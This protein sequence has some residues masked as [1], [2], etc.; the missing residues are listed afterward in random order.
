MQ[1]QNISKFLSI[2]VSDEEKKPLVGYALQFIERVKY[3][4]ACDGLGNA[5]PPNTQ[6]PHYS[7]RSSTHVPT[8]CR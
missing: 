5:T 1:L 7:R 8:R 4:G 2:V 6:S 3:L